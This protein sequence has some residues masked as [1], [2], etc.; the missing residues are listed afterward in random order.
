MTTQ[1]SIIAQW[2]SD[3]A[4]IERWKQELAE[5]QAKW[6]QIKTTPFKHRSII[7]ETTSALAGIEKAIE[8]RNSWVGSSYRSWK[9]QEEHERSGK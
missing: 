5:M 7:S 9:R 2:E 6:N 3:S 1:E 4:T 8:F